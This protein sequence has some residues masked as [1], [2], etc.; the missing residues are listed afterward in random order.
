MDEPWVYVERTMVCVATRNGGEGVA[1]A[2][3]AIELNPDVAY[4]SSFR[5][6][7]LAC[8][9]DGVAAI[10]A[11]D[12]AVRLSPRD[13]LRDEFDLFYAFAHLR[14]GDYARQ[15]ILL[16]QPR[17][18]GRAM[19]ILTA[20]W[21]RAARSPAIGSGRRRRWR[22]FWRSLRTSTLPRRR[23]RTCISGRYDGSSEA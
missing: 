15:R 20:C 7:A 19:P 14:R 10:A 6:V 13:L 17:R 4:G 2:R 5:G 16:R 23:A 22:T 21:R 12:R 11:V 9:G 1:A 3:K 18:C 8:S